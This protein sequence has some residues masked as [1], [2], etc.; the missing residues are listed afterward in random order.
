MGP[1][2]APVLWAIGLIFLSLLIAVIVWRL[3]G[4]REVV[5]K[6]PPAGQNRLPE[7]VSPGEQLSKRPAFQD[8]AFDM[9]QEGGFSTQL[10]TASSNLRIEAIGDRSHFVVNGATYPD[11]ESIPDRE[12]RSLAQRLYEK[13]FAPGPLGNAPGEELRQALV[14]SQTT[15][16][17][18]SPD[19]TI[20]IQSEGKSTR[21][22]INGLSHQKLN[23]ITDPELR[24]MTQELRKRMV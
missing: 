12:L 18:R 2:Q 11:V 13:A 21:Y 14:G 9:T 15:I 5:R 23:D 24:R 1:L 7:D 19:Y 4:E 10:Q 17:A 20:S 6:P 8:V 16:E 22:I 3:R